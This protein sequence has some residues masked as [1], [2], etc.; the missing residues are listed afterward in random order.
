MKCSSRS[1][2]AFF[3]GTA[4]LFF[5]SV[6]T[7]NAVPQSADSQSPQGD[8][9]LGD[10]I[11]GGVV[12]EGKLWLRGAIVSREDVSGGLVSLS[13]AD[14]SRAYCTTHLSY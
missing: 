8:P 6:S 4:L 14:D 9:V 10:R 2:Y 3:T 7:L 13:L 5:L 11:T 1:S 12:F